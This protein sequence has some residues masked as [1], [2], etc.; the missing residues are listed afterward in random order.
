MAL[1]KWSIF[2][3]P[4]NEAITVDHPEGMTGTWG[5]TNLTG[6]QLATGLL[7]PSAQQTIDVSAIAAGIYLFSVRSTAGRATRRLIIAR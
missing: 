4:A 1:T 5:I 7:E 3:N 6:Q 2:P